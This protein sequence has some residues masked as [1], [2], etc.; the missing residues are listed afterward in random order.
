MVNV[1]GVACYTSR[2]SD[3]KPTADIKPG[4]PPLGSKVRTIYFKFAMLPEHHDH[5]R[6][7]AD[8][9]GVSIAAYLRILI[10]RDMGRPPKEED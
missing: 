6:A 5:L 1:G 8:E 10:E 4:Q 2:M 9:D 3:E 7:R